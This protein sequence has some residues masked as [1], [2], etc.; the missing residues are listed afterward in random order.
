MNEIVMII[1]M[2]FPMILFTIYPGLKLSEYLDNK[3]DIGETK[4]RAVMLSVMFV[5]ALVL[6]AALNLVNLEWI[7]K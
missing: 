7:F 5:F 3:Y 2:A 6:S 1:V 4:K